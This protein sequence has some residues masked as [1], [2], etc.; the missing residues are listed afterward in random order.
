M[1]AEKNELEIDFVGSQKVACQRVLTR[2]PTCHEKIFSD[3]LETN[4]S[5]SKE[6]GV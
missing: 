6:L 4:L 3:F 1:R 2:V 5:A